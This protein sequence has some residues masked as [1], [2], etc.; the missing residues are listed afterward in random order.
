MPSQAVGSGSAAQQP[1]Q[2]VVRRQLNE[3]QQRAATS[4]SDKPLLILAGAGSGKTTTIV[5]RIKH[6]IIDK[7]QEPGGSDDPLAD[8]TPAQRLA[9]E[10]L[11]E[12]EMIAGAVKGLVRTFQPERFKDGKEPRRMPGDK[13]TKQE[14]AKAQD[15]VEQHKSRG[16]EPDPIDRE[17]LTYLRYQ[18]ILKDSNCMDFNDL[19]I[20]G[21]NVLTQF[22]WIR[23]RACR[24]YQYMLV[25]EFQDCNVL[26]AELVNLLQREARRVTVVGDDAQSIY[27]FRGAY[28]AVFRAFKE[29]YMHDDLQRAL[30]ENYSILTAAGK[31]L[32]DCKAL[33][34]KRLRPTKRDTRV[35]IKLWELGTPRE[36][37][38]AMADEILWL[39]EQEGLAYEDIACL[40]R[41][42]K[43]GNGPK[44]H[45]DLQHALTRRSIPFR[46]VRGMSI[47]DS[48]VV[49]DALAYVR[50]LLNP[51]DDGALMRIINVPPR[52]LGK[53]FMERLE[54]AQDAL[55]LTAEAHEE[56]RAGHAEDAEQQDHSMMRAAENLLRDGLLSTAH[57]NSLRR[58]LDLVGA[59]RME[60]LAMAVHEALEHVLERSGYLE[61]LKEVAAKK[62]K[63]AAQQEAEGGVS[64]GGDSRADAKKQGKTAP[65]SQD[66]DDDSESEID[67]R[68]EAPEASQAEGEEAD[69]TSPAKG[70]GTDSQQSPGAGQQAR[71]APPLEWD[72]MGRQNV[73]I[74]LQDGSAEPGI[75][76]GQEEYQSRLALPKYLQALVR[77]AASFVRDWQGHLDVDGEGVVTEDGVGPPTL[78]R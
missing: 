61:H 42:F 13:P 57:S 32:T 47:M 52:G 41:N 63:K 9:A 76:P 73:D 5:A 71:L 45:E 20:V 2:P 19:L 8:L 49:K 74:C 59:L 55:R 27:L 29:V 39:H 51:R 25:D 15:F 7:A 70:R 72:R 50:L 23:E 30:E 69:V 6:L 4:A 34:P 1:S 46:I 65:G 17:G 56:E 75:G 58:F 64:A 24:R 10:R 33:E 53:G 48:A 68:E 67:D 44:M 16:F 43:F 35:P 54:K 31:A 36:E 26:Q 40:F 28:P 11:R 77:E 22:A 3:E 60:T 37:A 38:E 66:N 12:L 62:R 21:R 78:Y 18:Q 14:V